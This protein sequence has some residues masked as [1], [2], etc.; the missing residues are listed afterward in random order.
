MGLWYSNYIHIFRKNAYWNIFNSLFEAS[1]NFQSIQMM[2]CS[3]RRKLLPCYFYVCETVGKNLFFKNH[4]A[5]TWGIKHFFPFFFCSLSF[6]LSCMYLVVPK[7][8]IYFLRVY[9][10]S[11]STHSPCNFGVIPSHI[12]IISQIYSVIIKLSILTS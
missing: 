12:K 2:R 5:E 9:M 4:C 3:Q 7:I 6:V 1:W 10:F 8:S 11:R